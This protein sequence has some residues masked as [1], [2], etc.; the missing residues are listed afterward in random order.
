MK[1]IKQKFLKSLTQSAIECK[2]LR[3]HYNLHIEFTDPC[4]RLLNAVEPF[5]YIRPH[6]HLSDPKT[7]CLLAIKGAFVVVFF[8][9][10][11]NIIRYFLLGSE[12]FSDQC[13]A[14]VEI[15]SSVW[16]TVVSLRSGSILF[17]AKEGPFNPNAA[18][19]YAPWAPHEND[20]ESAKRYLKFVLSSCPDINVI[21]QQY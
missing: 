17:E 19:D 1:I 13:V 16:H 3:R 14:L 15:P 7:E 9:D 2:R 20:N 11:G 6:R 12:L 10:E 4:Q 21:T 8:D 18:K 5:S